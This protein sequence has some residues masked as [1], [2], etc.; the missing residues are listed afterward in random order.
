MTIKR[1]SPNN[2]N[3]VPGAGLDKNIY[4]K[5]GDVNPLIDQVN[6]NTTAIADFADGSYKFDHIAELTS[7]HGITFD[8]TPNID[9]IAEKTLNHGV[10]IDGVLL[11]DSAVD[12]NVAAAGV[13]LSGTTLAADGTDADIDINITPKGTGS[14]L[15]AKG[16]VTALTS[17]TANITT[18]DTNVAAAGVTVAGTTIA[19]D[20][21]DAAIPI[22]IT[23]KGVAGILTTAGSAAAPA[24]SFTGDPNTG[25]IDSSA[26]AIGFV[27]NAIEQW[28]INASG[29]LVP[30]VS[31]N[32]IGSSAAAVEKVY[33]QNEI[34][35]ATDAN[36][37]YGLMTRKYVAAKAT[38]GAEPTEITVGIPAGV[39]LL[40]VQFT[41]STAITAATATSWKAS[42]TGGSSAVIDAGANA[43]A[44]N[45]KLNVL[46]SETTMAATAVTTN[47]T[48]ISIISNDA[49]DF[50]SGE[51]SAIV[52]Y[53]ELTSITN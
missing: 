2:R 19:A 32:D 21:T 18:L 10:I 8:N 34:I 16:T 53:E 7:A 22:T 12:T 17:T 52:Y 25:I 42:F 14:L 46:L 6:A 39:R 9:T 50:T 44:L 35:K 45:T 27:T 1:I 15:T 49:S 23:P 11:K 36:G 29:S 48:Q 40:A 51:I 38:L 41:V 28:T 24:Y 31:T 30:A 47:T 33:S 20:G 26:D 5:A 13:T 3:V 37:F 43:F 4:V